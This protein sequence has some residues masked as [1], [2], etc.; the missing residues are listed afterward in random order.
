MLDEIILKIV[1]G[2]IVLLALIY[3]LRLIGHYD[4]ICFYSTAIV[5]LLLVMIN[6]EVGE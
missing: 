6:K 3:G 5:S 1:L 4:S 2:T